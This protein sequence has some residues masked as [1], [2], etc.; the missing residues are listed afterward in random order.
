MRPQAAG[1]IPLLS[2]AEARRIALYAQG[3]HR[4][5]PN[6]RITT[7][8]IRRTIN[9]LGLLQLDYVN[10]LVPAHYQ[11]LFS[12][13]GAYDRSLLDK[14]VYKNREFT[15]QWA[16][17][18]SIVPMELWPLLRHRREAH[19]IRPHGFDRFLNEY[20][21]YVAGVL[22]EIEARGARTAEDFADPDGI[23]PDVA[24]S[25]Y[26][27]V[28][29]AVL[30][31][32]FARGFLA[33]AGRRSNLTR[34]YD[35][36]ERVISQDHFTRVVPRQDA[37]RELLDRAGRA[38]GI[39]TAADLADYYRMSSKDCRI[40]LDELVEA[41][42]LRRVRVE[43]WRDL[44]YLHIEAKAPRSAT[45]AT[46]LSPFDP[47]IWFRPR[48]ER[49][50]D[51]H[52][53]IEIYTPEAQRKWGYYVLPFLLHERIVAR[54]DLKADRAN[55]RLLVRAAHIEPGADPRAVIPSLHGE[56]H[57]WADW[58]NLESIVVEPRGALSLPL[59]RYKPS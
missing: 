18:A 42:R 15:E 23:S 52:Y 8:D 36:P 11:V 29:R 7:A 38:H 50:F 17:E 6:R 3:L 40:R 12:R 2:L 54:V 49:L 35:L 32:H 5:R 41:G 26:G 51:F 24:G 30:E 57:A 16:H 13:L 1:S 43:N 20:A 53:R 48:T 55:R 56:L 58:L 47:L 46:F 59:Q 25:W 22:T 37:E 10:V 28:A 9:R 27:T 39:A 31:A 19:R 44:A 34:L 45:A 21:H 33:I 4:P 14:L